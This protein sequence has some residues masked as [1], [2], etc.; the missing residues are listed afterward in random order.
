M[1]SC[2]VGARLA[3]IIVA[4]L[5]QKCSRFE[6]P[7]LQ[8]AT[9]SVRGTQGDAAT[10]CRLCPGLWGAA[11][12]G[13]GLRTFPLLPHT[14]AVC[15]VSARPSVLPSLHYKYTPLLC[16]GKKVPLLFRQKRHLW[17]T[18][19]GRSRLVPGIMCKFAV[20]N[21][22]ILTDAASKRL[23]IN[24]LGMILAATGISEKL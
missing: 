13:R 23:R 8:G 12:S 15:I 22:E 20:R 14:A 16:G 10:S 11:P 1:G 3:D 2:P 18:N 7:T 24:G 4:F 21:D 17:F 9:N 6:H 5:H 19:F